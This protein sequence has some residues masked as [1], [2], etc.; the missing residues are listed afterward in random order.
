MFCNSTFIRSLLVDLLFL[1]CLVY[2]CINLFRSTCFILPR[3]SYFYSSTFAKEEEQTKAEEDEEDD[4]V[5]TDPAIKLDQGFDDTKPLP[6]Y[7]PEQRE[8]IQDAVR[9]PRDDLNL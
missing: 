9:S 8:L 3:T 1:R 2:F 7:T 4:D 6:H 5:I